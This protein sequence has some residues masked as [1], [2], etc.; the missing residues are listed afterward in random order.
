MI[1]KSIAPIGAS[2]KRPQTAVVNNSDMARAKSVFNL[3]NAHVKGANGRMPLPKETTLYIAFDASGIAGKVDLLT[4]TT[5]PV[6][7]ITNFDGNKFNTGRNAVIRSLRVLYST[8]GDGLT[9]ADWQNEDRLPAELQNA[10]LVI[11]Q[12]GN[13]VVSIPLTDL[14]GDK[15]VAWRSFSNTPFLKNNEPI[16]IQISM[17]EGVTAPIEK[18]KTATAPAVKS[19]LRLE[20]RVFETRV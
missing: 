20:S 7:G 6:V 1:R 11:T 18:A 4:A 8:D 3:N 14:Q 13:A 16:S 9:S 19:Y 17:P 10:E 2:R 12:G 5:K 15:F